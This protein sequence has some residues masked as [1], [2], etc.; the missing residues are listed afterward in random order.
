MRLIRWEPF[1]GIEDAKVTVNNSLL[2]TAHVAH[3]AS[4]DR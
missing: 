4:I 2:R 3:S 1:A